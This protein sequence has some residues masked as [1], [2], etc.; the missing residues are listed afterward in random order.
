[1][2][3]PSSATLFACA[4]LH[5]KN[6]WD[7]PLSAATHSS[8][9]HQLFTF[10]NLHIIESALALGYPNPW[11]THGRKKKGSDCIACAKQGRLKSQHAHKGQGQGLRPPGAAPE[12]ARDRVKVCVYTQTSFNQQR[13]TP[14]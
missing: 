14:V 5:K 6:V 10:S 8:G 13:A 2:V 11:L 12:L 9:T 4:C 7:Q 3:T 1:M